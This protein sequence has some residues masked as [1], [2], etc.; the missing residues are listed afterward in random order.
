[1]ARRAPTAYIMGGYIPAGG[2]RMAY[3]IG[4]VAHQ[5]F[6]I[7][8]KIITA[9]D[10]SLEKSV[11]DYPIAFEATN[12]VD[13]RSS[14]RPEDILV[15]NPSFSNGRVGLEN[16]C[17]KLMYVQG[18]NTF[19]HL[20]RWFQTYV[21]VGSFVQSFLKNVYSV[22]ADVIPPFIEP[23]SSN[24]PSW[25]ARPTDSV[26]FFLKGNESLQ[27]ALLAR[28]QA[29][30]TAIDSAVSARIDWEGSI[31]SP[32]GHPQ[33]ALHTWLGERRHLVTL[34]IGEGF[35]LVPLEAMSAGTAV[36]GFDGFG[37]RDYMRSGY[38]C[39]VRHYPDI[40]GLAYDLVK[41]LKQPE[42]IGRMSAAGPGTA[43]EFT[44]DRFH[45]AWEG[46]LA[47]VLET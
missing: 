38:N 9:G 18:F 34:S 26:W 11:F 12:Y 43:A 46:V 28:L 40:A 37:G 24:H 8:C 16:D 6:G 4:V 17:K 41:A 15:C 47:R 42:R 32:G 20:D 13:F 10:E 27:R 2:T 33:S 19:Q 45:A 29:E 44:K 7:P 21:A 14:V 3:E 23:I 5:R 30:V 35:G 39:A 22:E 36:L 1:M 25:W 31:L